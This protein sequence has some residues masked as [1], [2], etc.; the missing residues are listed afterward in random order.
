MNHNPLMKD[1]ISA[2]Q[3]IEKGKIE[4][5]FATPEK[6]SPFKKEGPLQLG[7]LALKEEAA[8]KIRVF[9][10]VDP[11]TQSILRPFHKFLFSFL[12]SLPNDGTHDQ[13]ASVKRCFQKSM[14]SGCSFGYDLSAAT[15]RLPIALQMSVIKALFTSK[16]G[17]GE[18]MA[19]AWHRLLVGR[20]YYLKDQDREL[21]YSVGQPMGALS[22]W[23]MLAVTHHLIVQLAAVRAGYSSKQW[24]ENYELLGDDINIFDAKVAEHYL[25]IMSMIGVPINAS[26]SVVAKNSTFEFAKVT[27]FLGR[28]VSAISWKMFI[29][30][31]TLLGRVN[32]LYSL[33]NKD[34]GISSPL[35]YLKALTRKSLSD[36][37]DER[38]SYLTLIS[39]YVKSGK[40]RFEDFFALVM[41]GADM[42]KVDYKS[43][44]S[45]VDPSLLRQVINHLVSGFE[46]IVV[47][48]TDKKGRH[49]PWSSISNLMIAEMMRKIHQFVSS[50]NPDLGF[51]TP[52]KVAY[53]ICQEALCHSGIKSVISQGDFL[54]LGRDKAQELQ[55]D[56]WRA[57]ANL[58]QE[59][60][61]PLLT[62]L[63]DGLPRDPVQPSWLELVSTRVRSSAVPN[64]FSHWFGLV[65]TIDRLREIGQ[66]VERALVKVNT[67]AKPH[68][69]KKEN[70]VKFVA[71]IA[72]V[73]K[74]SLKK[75]LRVRPVRKK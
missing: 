68:L 52:R 26:K 17:D 18:S 12:K 5:L 23:A 33:F 31:N 60:C 15:D 35:R 67:E 57:L 30:Q 25:D 40:Y 54:Y 74:N 38:F 1:L 28:N 58:L 34:I 64:E 29:S 62:E 53:Q 36:Q 42:T 65:D 2:L 16:Y 44:E 41:R 47:K 6:D 24:F 70:P 49:H 43:L 11:W 3:E 48:P 55:T 7:Q 66:L 51:D 21:T 56:L 72:R 50:F 39:M 69:T 8:G 10:M 4:G 59:E 13:G 46:P 45:G 63:V 20:P 19:I 61:K 14:K 32:I 71:I 37:G 73:Y 22:S 27:G 9:A 75:V